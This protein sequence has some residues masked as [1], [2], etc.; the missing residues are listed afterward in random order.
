MPQ[1]N[2]PE[3]LIAR[4]VLPSLLCIGVDCKQLL[5]NSCKI[6][7]Y[8]QFGVGVFGYMTSR[9]RSNRCNG[10]YAGRQMTTWIFL[11]NKLTTSNKVQ[12]GGQSNG[13]LVP[14]GIGC[15]VADAHIGKRKVVHNYI[16]QISN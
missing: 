4:V 9:G 3:H 10:M 2:S 1:I 5:S 16:L 13:I 8:R 11:A 12:P 14:T 6:S 7:L 15:F